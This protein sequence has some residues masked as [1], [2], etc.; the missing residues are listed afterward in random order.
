MS[1][2]ESLRHAG[3]TEEAEVEIKW[4]HADGEIEKPGFEHLFSGVDALIVPGGFDKRGIEGKIQ[5]IRYARETGLPF[6]GICLGLQCAVVEYARNVCG[7]EDANSFEIAPDSP[8]SVIHLMSDQIG[9][10]NRGGTMRLGRYPC[11]ITSDR[12]AE[13]YGS[14]EINERHRHRYEVNNAYRETLEKHG[15]RIAGTSPDGELVEMIELPDHPWFVGCQFHPEFRSR[16]DR[17]HPL[18][19]GLVQAALQRSSEA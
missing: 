15:L 1:I 3:A 9:I 10:S 8:H 2:I 12:L 18:F 11:H 13:M 17:P 16:P 5:A 19:R 4:L 14:R 6:L 7:L